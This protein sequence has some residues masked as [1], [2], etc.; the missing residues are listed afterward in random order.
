VL[1]GYKEHKDITEI[2]SLCGACNDVCPVKIPLV[3]CILEHRRIIAEDKKLTTRTEDF[4]FSQYG[5]VIG[6]PACYASATR[7]A[8][9]AARSPRIGP[10]GEWT[11]AREMPEI[12]G[13]R[14]RDWFAGR[15]KKASEP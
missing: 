13:K 11:R 8:R 5:R 10:I 1:A 2:C 3:E 4:I 12:P 14:F 6:N 7:L 9:W 15:K